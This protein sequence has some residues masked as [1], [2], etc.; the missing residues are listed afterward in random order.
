MNISAR[1]ESKKVIT[2]QFFV[3][4]CFLA[5]SGMTPSNSKAGDLA[6]QTDSINKAVPESLEERGKQ[7]R[8]AIDQAY[9]KLPHHHFKK[10]EGDITPVVEQFIPV[11]TSFDDAEE[12]LR[13]AGFK[14]GKRPGP[15]PSPA[16]FGDFPYKYDV[17]AVIDPYE[18]FFGGSIGLSVFLSPESPENYSKVT[19]IHAGFAGAYL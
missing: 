6:N 9:E 17:T 3:F 7:L 10:G 5:L 4:I 8:V 12:I 11:G 2:F 15:N 14:V 16:P 1:E 13:A 18:S 19:K